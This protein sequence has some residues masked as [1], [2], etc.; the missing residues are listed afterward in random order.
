VNT[1]SII[2]ENWAWMPRHLGSF[3]VR[4]DLTAYREARNAS[5]V[6][7]HLSKYGRLV[8]YIFHHVKYIPPDKDIDGYHQDMLLIHYGLK[9]NAH[10][11]RPANAGPVHQLVG[12]QPKSE[13]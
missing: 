9:P 8:H 4:H 1:K 6:W 5:K 7:K 11:D 13:E 10:D 3:P 12:Q 2:E